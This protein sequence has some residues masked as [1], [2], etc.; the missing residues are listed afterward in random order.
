MINKN[1]IDRYDGI[2]YVDI[3]KLKMSD[4]TH[5]YEHCEIKWH[6][7]L[8]LVDISSKSKK[9]PTLVIEKENK[10][11]LLKQTTTFL[12]NRHL[13][14][15]QFLHEC[16]NHS[17]AK[18]LNVRQKQPFVT[19]CASFVPLTA[20]KNSRTHSWINVD[21]VSFEQLIGMHKKV[22][23]NDCTGSLPLAVNTTINYLIGKLDDTR[24][25][26]E[27]TLHE[28]LVHRKDIERLMHQSH[29]S[30]DMTSQS[31]IAFDGELMDKIGKEMARMLL[32][33]DEYDEL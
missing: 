1:A 5:K 13:R 2:N 31:P 25:M 9:F 14:K 26:K 19:S 33:R 6:K 3:G 28:F 24:R 12:L 8:M 21:L 29:R 22:L 4:I 32:E 17:V 27:Y 15:E 11:Y 10:F 23:L 16:R 30:R 18:Y 7:L 20:K